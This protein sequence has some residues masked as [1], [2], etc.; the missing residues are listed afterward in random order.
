MLVPYFPILPLTSF[1]SLKEGGI[2]NLSLTKNWKKKRVKHIHPFLPQNCSHFLPKQTDS[3]GDITRLILDDSKEYQ[4]NVVTVCFRLQD[5]KILLMEFAFIFPKPK[6]AAPTGYSQN[7]LQYILEYLLAL[8]YGL[9][10]R[11]WKYNCSSA[12]ALFLVIW[13]ET[14]SSSQENRYKTISAVQ[15][16]G[17]TLGPLDCGS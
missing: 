4:E 7:R 2:F 10:Q 1:K 9:G 8:K 17:G 12:Y 11:T 16:D 14:M 3:S 5:F 13:K 15:A 6:R